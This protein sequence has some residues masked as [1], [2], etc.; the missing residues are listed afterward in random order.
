MGPHEIAELLGV[1]RQ[2]FQQLTR[3]P[4]FP[5]PYQVLRAA[6]I[7]LRADI[8][9]WIKQHRAPRADAED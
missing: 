7:W 4:T 9:A 5:K 2:R 3:Y 8:E 6:K 1:S